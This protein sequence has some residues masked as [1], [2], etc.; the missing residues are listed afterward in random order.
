MVLFCFH[1][2]SGNAPSCLSQWGRAGSF[3]HLSQGKMEGDTTLLIRQ[4]REFFLHR[5][6]ECYHAKLCRVLSDTNQVFKQVDHQQIAQVF[7]NRALLHV[8][9]TVC[10]LLREYQCIKTYTTLS[11]NLSVINGK[12]PMCY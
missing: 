2:Q 3:R 7:E 12:M 9:T 8:M 5:H 6:P 4:F 10:S 11:Y 1:V